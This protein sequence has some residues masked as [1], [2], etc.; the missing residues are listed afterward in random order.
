MTVV[1]DKQWS[2]SGFQCEKL[3]EDQNLVQQIVV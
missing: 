2:K 1:I 3:V